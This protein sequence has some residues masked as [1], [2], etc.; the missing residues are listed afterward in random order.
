LVNAKQ[1][2]VWTEQQARYE[3]LSSAG[4]RGGETKAKN[5]RRSSDASSDATKSVE[6]AASDALAEKLAIAKQSE[7]EEAVESPLQGS[8]PASAPAGA[9]GVGAPRLPARPDGTTSPWRDPSPLDPEADRLNAEYFARLNAKVDKWAV[10]NPD[11]AV[12]VEKTLRT[13]MGLPHNRELSGFQKSALRE[14]FLVRVREQR[15]WPDCD[16]WIAL[17]RARLAAA[18][19]AKTSEVAA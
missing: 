12:E 19:T 11:D 18:D 16:E 7:L 2:A 5:K 15:G 3:R 6:H 8:L 14:Q 9:L 1:M 17:E 4:K 13:E 10:E